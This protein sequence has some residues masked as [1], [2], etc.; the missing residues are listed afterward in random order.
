M[1]RASICEN[2]ALALAIAY[3]GRNVPV[4]IIA[5]CI[6]E[7]LQGDYGHCRLAA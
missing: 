1:L 3:W 4:A 7:F 6:L 5:Y 2:I